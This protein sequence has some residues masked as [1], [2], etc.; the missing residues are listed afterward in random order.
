MCGIVG[1]VGN[2]IC[3][4]IILGSL[5]RL[6]YRGYD[7]S[8][9]ATIYNDQIQLRRT[10][11]KLSELKAK[12]IKEPVSGTIGIGHIRWAT[13]GGVTE[14]NAHPHLVNS[15]VA[16]VHNGIIENYVELKKELTDKGFLFSSDTDSEVLAHLFANVIGQGLKPVEALKAV[17]SKIEGAY[18]FAVLSKSHPGTLMVARNASPLAIGISDDMVIVASDATAMAHLTRQVTYLK[19][20]DYAVITSKRLDIYNG[21]NEPANREVVKVN[22]S[23]ILLDKAGFKHYMEKEIHEQPDAI[24][25]TISA[26]TDVNGGISAGLDVQSLAKMKGIV[27]L[28]AGTSFYAAQIGRYWIERLAGVPVVCEIASEY[29]YRNP[30]ASHQTTAIVI[31]QSGESIDSLMAIR[32]AKNLGLETYG[33][34]NVVDSTIS[35]EVDKILPTRAGPEIGVAST[36]A[37][38]AQLVVLI[39]LAI[40]LGRQNGRLDVDKAVDIHQGLLKIPGAVGKSMTLFDSI[41]PIANQLKNSRSCLF[42]GR[43]ILFPLACEGALKLK[44]LSYIHA[45]GF[46]SGEM[47]HGPIALLEKGLPVVSFVSEDESARKSVSNLKEAEAR[48]GFIIVIGT[49]NAVNLIDFATEKIII[50]GCDPLLTPILSAVPAQILAYLTASEKGTDIDQP[51]N[52]AKS[53]TVE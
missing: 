51:R 26:M 22:V 10:V 9:I 53:V 23:P 7:S 12:I 48:G 29:H 50:P 44:E 32:H 41:L 4:E 49:Q 16:I 14:Q 46:A 3:Q 34:V 37:F 45:E 1:Y 17:L 36:K 31:S 35:R 27:L 28:A 24:S 42:L 43:D 18:S 2:K 47:K 11:G 40:S 8:G 6:E 13:H 19:D 25:H 5:E 21:K 30:V 38:T 33:I 39:C 15:E 52:L 20:N